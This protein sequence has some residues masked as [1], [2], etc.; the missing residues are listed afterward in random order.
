MV[1]ND[2]LDFSKIESG[3]LEL[4]DDPFDLR[5]C[6]EGALRLVTV[7]AG[8]KGLEL[9]VDVSPGLPAAASAATPPGCAR[10]WSTCS[11]TP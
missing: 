1:I 10:C 6:L 5:E 2:I 9:V 8:L 7:P 3:R 11:T 4:D